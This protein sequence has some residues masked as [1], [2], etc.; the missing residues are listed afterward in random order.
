MICFITTKKMPAFNFSW[1]Y[2]QKY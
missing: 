2:P 1:Y